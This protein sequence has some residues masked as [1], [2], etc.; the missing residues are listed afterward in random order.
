M[1]EGRFFEDFEVGMRLRHAVPRTVTAG[2]V[3]VYLSM[4]GDRR[5]VFCSAEFARA[6]G[7]ESTPVHELLVF[8][9]VFGQSVQDV[10]L[11]AVANLGY[12]EVQFHRSVFVGD[13]LSACSD[14]IGLKQTSSGTSG[15]VYVTTRGYNQ[16]GEQVLSYHRWV[17]VN[18]RD[19]AAPPPA[20][21]VP[22]L[23]GSLDVTQLV[24]PPALTCVAF[25][26][27]QWATGGYAK[28]DSFQ[29]GQRRSSGVGATIDDAEHASITRLYQN[30]ARVHHDAVFMAQSK[31]G[32]RLV[33]GGHVISVA[34]AL[35]VT[36][37]ENALHMI[38]WNSGV[39][40]N[41]VVAGD[42]LYAGTEILQVA[43][44]AG[45]SDLGAV[46]VRL[47]ASKNLQL[48]REV[49][50]PPPS[51]GQRLRYNPNL[52]LDLDYWAVCPR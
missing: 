35:G 47:V 30:S 52:V 4:T 34:Y 29:S 45:R 9:L 24:I 12:A 7:Y 46:R 5:A 14:V 22:T 18:K 1:S 27:H 20:P 21:Q 15:I 33:Y 43:P 8:H 44:L 11:N 16:R 6:L 49:D 42:T 13:T 50:W 10:S 37:L 3:A 40:A 41:P 36:G 17:L 38:G 39:H 26:D 48:G 25:D 19:S 2:D 28:W 32:H 31:L 23:P 51:R